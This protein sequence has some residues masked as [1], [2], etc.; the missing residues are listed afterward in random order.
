MGEANTFS[1]FF[2]FCL[3][4]LSLIMMAD[5]G[6]AP[7]VRRQSNTVAQV[8]ERAARRR[9]SISSEGKVGCDIMNCSFVCLFLG[10]VKTSF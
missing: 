10:A 5:A 3:S 4:L 9:S 7:A 1:L 2:L 6:E 8:A